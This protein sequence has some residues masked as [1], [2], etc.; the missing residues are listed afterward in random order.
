MNLQ[1]GLGV[2]VVLEPL[3]Y[4]DHPVR[5]QFNLYIDVTLTMNYAFL[6]AITESMDSGSDLNQ[7]Q[8]THKILTSCPCLPCGPGGPEGPASP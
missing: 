3:G 4:Q 7:N 6:E 8:L 2:Q 1:C 5:S